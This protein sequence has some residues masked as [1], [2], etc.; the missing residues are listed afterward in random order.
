MRTKIL[1]WLDQDPQEPLSAIECSPFGKLPIELRLHI[2]SFLAGPGTIH[3]WCEQNRLSNS[4]CLEGIDDTKSFGPLGTLKDL[5]A[6]E[7]FHQAEVAAE[8]AC[9]HAFC[10]NSRRLPYRPH[11]TFSL[12]HTCRILHTEANSLIDRIYC[13]STFYFI[14]THA[15][16]LFVDSLSPYSKALL[17][18]LHLTLD[19]SRTYKGRHRPLTDTFNRLQPNP[20]TVNGPLPR[21]TTDLKPCLRLRIRFNQYRT[22][23]T[24]YL[25]LSSS[26]RRLVTRLPAFLCR[27][28]LVIVP[29][30]QSPHFLPLGAPAGFTVQGARAPKW[31]TK[32]VPSQ[33]PACFAAIVTSVM[34]AR[35][36]IRKAEEQGVLGLNQWL[37][38]DGH[39]RG[40]EAWWKGEE[41]EVRRDMEVK[42]SVMFAV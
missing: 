37:C 8:T 39:G 7:E 34:E 25:N 35:H 24:F 38:D 32:L 5:V 15:F 4:L 1:N 12:F 6:S 31:F 14:H 28:I 18:K 30:L 29:S 33:N 21:P 40:G 22:D 42:F 9:R 41:G 3:I 2:Y 13:N 20:Y 19:A 26:I 36:Q 11:L 27:T 16:E 10:T 17:R 23:E